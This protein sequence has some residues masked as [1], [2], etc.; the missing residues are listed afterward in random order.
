MKLVTPNRGSSFY[1]SFSDLIFGTMAILVLLMIVFLTMI[2]QADAQK[3]E[4]LEK[5]VKQMAEELA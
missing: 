1:E 2:N 3:R 5:Q 4:E